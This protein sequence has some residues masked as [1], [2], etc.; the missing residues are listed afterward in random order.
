LE[1]TSMSGE[2]R[3][4]H[5]SLE[6]AELVAS[7]RSRHAAQDSSRGIY[8]TL[9]N[10]TQLVYEQR[11]GH[12]FSHLVDA[13]MPAVDASIVTMHTRSLLLLY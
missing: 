8:S 6:R 1:R 3:R 12:I 10:Q 9:P 5:A 2:R 4:K 7:S 11:R 13:Q